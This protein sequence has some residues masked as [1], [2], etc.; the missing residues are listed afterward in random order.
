E[1]SELAAVYSGLAHARL[2][3]GMYEGTAVMFSESVQMY[4]HMVRGRIDASLA[5]SLADYGNFYCDR[6]DHAKAGPLLQMAF[7]MFRQLF[8]DAD[9]PGFARCLTSL[10]VY[11]RLRGDYAQAE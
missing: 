1:R 4:R 7:E 9:D 5:E 3:L 2:G 8:P 6:G 11:H 10:A